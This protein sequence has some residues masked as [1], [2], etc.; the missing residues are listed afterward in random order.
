MA[1]RLLGRRHRYGNGHDRIT[2]MLDSGVRRTVIE[3][4]GRG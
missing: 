1:P 2:A 3:R 4:P